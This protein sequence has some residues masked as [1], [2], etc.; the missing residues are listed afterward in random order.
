VKASLTGQDQ[1]LSCDFGHPCAAL[2]SCEFP[3]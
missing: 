3:G 1:D 2:T